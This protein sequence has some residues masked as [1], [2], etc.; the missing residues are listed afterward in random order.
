MVNLLIKEVFTMFDKLDIIEV[1][2]VCEE[3][4]ANDYLEKGWVLLGIANSQDFEK[5]PIFKYCLGR[6]AD[7]PNRK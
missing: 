1:A 2:S 7:S 6:L 4:I 5:F 3:R